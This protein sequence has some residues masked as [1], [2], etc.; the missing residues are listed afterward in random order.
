M[1]FHCSFFQCSCFLTITKSFFISTIN[2]DLQVGFMNV[3]W[4]SLTSLQ[5]TVLQPTLVPLSLPWIFYAWTCLRLGN[6]G[7]DNHSLEVV[8]L[9]CSFFFH[10]ESVCYFMITLWTAVFLQLIW[11]LISCSQYLSLCN[12]LWMSFSHF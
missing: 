7:F 10:S 1:F 11:A 8:L 12:S 4:N 2:L 9:E 6:N 3:L 5:E